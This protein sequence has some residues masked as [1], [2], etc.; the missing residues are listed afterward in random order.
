[1]AFEARKFV[2]TQKK[3]IPMR[4]PLR[5]LLESNGFVRIVKFDYDTLKLIADAHFGIYPPDMME[6]LSPHTVEGK[7]SAVIHAAD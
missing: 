5:R 7:I 6:Q 1:M 3:L 2:E 4:T